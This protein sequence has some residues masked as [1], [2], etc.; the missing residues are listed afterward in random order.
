MP[1]A[2]DAA[3]ARIAELDA[4]ARACGWN[5]I[6]GRGSRPC[7]QNGSDP[8]LRSSSIADSRS[9]SKRRHA[10]LHRKG[11][12]RGDRRHDRKLDSLTDVRK[13]LGY[14]FRNLAE[15][16]TPGMIFA[17]ELEKALFERS[18]VRE[19]PRC[20]LVADAPAMPD[21]VPLAVERLEE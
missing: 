17:C 16:S 1:A 13:V 8:E 10:M 11:S 9:R 21:D 3:L 7:P 5:G 4:A 18:Q 20:S 15:P 12:I 19:A 2:K 14:I 6:C